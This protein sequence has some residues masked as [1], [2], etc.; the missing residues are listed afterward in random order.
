[1]RSITA[2]VLVAA[3]GG[4]PRRPAPPP[5]APAI[6][7]HRKAITRQIQ[8]LI[9]DEI[10]SSIVV[11][12]YDAGRTEIYGFGKGPGGAPPTATTLFEIGSVTKVYTSL[13]LADAI[14]RRE[15]SL[16][17]PVSDLLPTGGSVP[18]RDHVA[19]TLRHL[20]LHSSGLPRLPPSILPNSPDPYAKLDE[21]ALYNDLQHTDLESAPGQQIVYS[22]YGVGLLGFA[23][24]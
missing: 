6:E 9:A 18:T 8:P 16:D 3:C 2:V 7:P 4:T 11:G 22:N 10:A 1:M 13:L 15:V 24:G 23:L 19:I 20:A 21:N 12:V 5:P 17:Q 14:Q